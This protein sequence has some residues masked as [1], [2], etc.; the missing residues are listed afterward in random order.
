MLVLVFLL[1]LLCGLLCRGSDLVNLFNLKI[2]YLQ[3][4]KKEIIIFD[5]T[6]V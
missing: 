6:I 4:V 3:Y 5:L 2:V 1:I